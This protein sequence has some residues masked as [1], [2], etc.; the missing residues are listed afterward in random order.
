MR[1]FVRMDDRFQPVRELAAAQYPRQADE[2]G[3]YRADGQND[4]RDGHHPRRFMQMLLGMM[5][6]PARA[7]K[8]HKELAKHVEG[9]QAGAAKRQKPYELVAM[10]TRERQPKNFILGKKPGK[11]RKAGNRQH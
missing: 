8:G 3:K 10:G 7:V 6:G 11:R 5:I 4:Q 2:A 9:R 1:L